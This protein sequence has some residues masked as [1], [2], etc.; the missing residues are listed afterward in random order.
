MDKR[1]HLTRVFGGCARGKDAQQ[2]LLQVGNVM[3][4]HFRHIV[5]WMGRLVQRS[6]S[7]WSGEGDGCI[8]AAMPLR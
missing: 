7:N 1:K 4:G 8:R 6:P 3:G 5:T 2:V